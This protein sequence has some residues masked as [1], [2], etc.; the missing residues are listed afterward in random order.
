MQGELIEHLRRVDGAVIAEGA[1][2][3]GPALWVGKREIAHFDGVQTLDVR[4]T[5]SNIASRRSE[6][7]AN[8]RIVLRPGS[9]DW[10]EVKIESPGDVEFAIS[11]VKEAVAAN[12][13]TAVP[14]LPP[15]GADLQ[16]RRRFH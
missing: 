9:S 16:R 14:G 8:D 12:L 15:T 1:F 7:R 10:L 13:E 4:L 11:L 2:S 6:L 5:R 3:P